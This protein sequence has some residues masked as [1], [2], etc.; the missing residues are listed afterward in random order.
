MV[1]KTITKV[2]VR[3]RIAMRVL[4]LRKVA[5]SSSCVSRRYS[6]AA[7]KALTSVKAIQP[8]RAGRTNRA[9]GS[10]MLA[11]VPFASA[12]RV[13]LMAIRAHLIGRSTLPITISSTGVADPRASLCAMAK[14]TR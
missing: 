8:S 9:M 4:R 11:S 13:M 7:V 2:A 14:A 3:E 5:T 12:T 1:M 10:Q 6:S